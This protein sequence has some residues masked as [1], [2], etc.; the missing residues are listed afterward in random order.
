MKLKKWPISFYAYILLVVLIPFK[1]FLSLAIILLGASVFFSQSI[2]DSIKNL[3][4]QKGTLFFICSYLVY[5]IGLLYTSNSSFGMR[6]IE[7]KLA[8]LLM[9]IIIGVT[10]K[11][12]NKTLNYLLVAF[13][14]SN[15]V[16]AISCLVINLV[17]NQFSYIP[18]YT[19]LSV[20]VSPNYFIIYID[21]C[22]VVMLN[23]VAKEKNS[24]GIALIIL[25]LLFFICFNL[26]LASKMG[27]MI[28]A[29]ILI[30]YGFKYL[31]R[32]SIFLP[33]ALIFL[34]LAFGTIFINTNP[35]AKSRFTNLKSALNSERIDKNT[36]ES[37]RIRLL[38]WE[39][40]VNIIKEH[41]LIGVGTGDSKDSLLE[42][43]KRAGISHALS[44]RYNAH[45]QYLEW[46]I[47]LGVLG[48]IVLEGYLVY[49]FWIALKNRNH[50][51]KW[52]IVI[53]SLAFLTESVLETQAGL[54]FFSTFSML[55][56]YH[57]QP[58]KS[59]KHGSKLNLL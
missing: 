1:S 6:E 59:L 34:G 47:T 7:Y 22:I 8:L 45:N 37:S 41:P 39:Q 18:T 50:L 10:P 43:Y 48:F 26:L 15:F 19:E 11:M 2:Q 14:I 16:T 53:F 54:I 30:Y 40:A 13:L 21:F 5:L 24:K 55:L 42:K 9:P 31:K 33:P 56:Y 46:L 12:S 3:R 23:K 44:N 38:V 49:L 4:K 25:L 17:E 58:I 35:K 20:F 28:M 57:F 27:I 51:L 32:Y 29:I 52:F 36:T